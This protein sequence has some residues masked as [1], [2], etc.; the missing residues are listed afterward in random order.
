VVHART[1]LA[2]LFGC[3]CNARG[4]ASGI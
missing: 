4:V 2:D 1:V 3:V